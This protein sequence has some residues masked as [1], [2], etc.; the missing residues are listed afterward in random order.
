MASEVTSDLK[1]EL[2]GLKNLGCCTHLALEGLCEINQT[3]GQTEVYHPLTSVAF[4]PLV[5][6]STYTLTG[7]IHDLWDQ[8]SSTGP[9]MDKYRGLTPWQKFLARYMTEEEAG[10]LRER[11]RDHT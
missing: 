2:R 5:K 9:S 6:R 7:K 11:I 10:R 1:F 3:D 8:P 4:S